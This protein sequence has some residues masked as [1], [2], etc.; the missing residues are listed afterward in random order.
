M[1]EFRGGFTPNLNGT[2]VIVATLLFRMVE[3]YRK[4]PPK[5]APPFV[6]YAGPFMAMLM[7]ESLLSEMK[8]KVSELD[9]RNF[10]Q[11]RDLVASK[12]G[13]YLATAV[14]RLKMLLSLLYGDEEVS[15]QQL[16]ATFRRGDLFKYLDD[17][18]F[19]FSDT[20]EVT[21]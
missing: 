9:H 7:G 6:G 16:S 5:G 17:A 8:I 20:S 11:A 2:Q 12:G 13:D 14:S 1:A 10:N 4:R 3:N 18:A 19:L 21:G 15:L